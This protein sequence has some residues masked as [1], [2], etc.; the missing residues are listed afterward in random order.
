MVLDYALQIKFDSLCYVEPRFEFQVQVTHIDGRNVHLLSDLLQTFIRV[1]SEQS[2]LR[3]SICKLLA[4]LNPSS[5]VSDFISKV[6]FR[7]LGS[8]KNLFNFV[9]GRFASESIA[10][11]KCLLLRLL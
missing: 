11:I 5:K 7:A 6:N 3:V 2:P 8:L 9:F 4:V 1:L 10:N